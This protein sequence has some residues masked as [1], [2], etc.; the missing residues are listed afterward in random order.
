MEFIRLDQIFGRKVAEGAESLL[1]EAG[2]RD[3]K[4]G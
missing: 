1:T 2:F 4:L 3:L